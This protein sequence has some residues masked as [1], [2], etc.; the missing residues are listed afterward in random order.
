[1]KIDLTVDENRLV[2]YSK[3]TVVKYNKI[4]HAN[5]GVDTLFSD[6]SKITT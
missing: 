1:M 2:G 5:G 3:K 4:R 6:N